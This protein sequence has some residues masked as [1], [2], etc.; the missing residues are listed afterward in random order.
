MVTGSSRGVGR[1]CALALAREGAKV[2]VAA[3]SVEENPRLPGTIYSVA[4]E[5]RQAGG[6]ALPL[7]VDVRK[8]AMLEKM[9]ETTL[10][11]FGRI[12]ILVNNAG[13]AWWYPVEETPARRF[14]LVMD[15]NFRAA[16]VATQLCIPHF[17]AQGY[18]HVVNM[19]PPVDNPK[20]VAGKCA[21]MVSKF[22]MT[23][24]GIALAEEL[25][26]EN[27]AVN[28]LWPVTLIESYATIN[29]G[30]GQKENWRK[31]D[32][33]ADALLELVAREPKELGSGQAFL[34]E[35]VLREAGVTDFSHYAC[36]PGAE[37]MKIPW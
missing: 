12:D 15:V 11:T 1:A 7:Q 23:Y 21:Y 4:E 22:G 27:I 32:I 5:I 19:S 28:A 6:E 13:A 20:L 14:D 8:E 29:L 26:G 2:V 24:L 35:E 16:H 34:D 9:V 30:L 37:P 33:L 17:R 10:E 18:G 36:V 31:A 25:A 3:K